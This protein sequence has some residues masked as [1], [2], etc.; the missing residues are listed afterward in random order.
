MSHNLMLGDTVP[1]RCSVWCCERMLPFIERVAPGNAAVRALEECMAVQ[2]AAEAAVQARVQST[3]PPLYQS[4]RHNFDPYDV[5]GIDT[6]TT[7]TLLEESLTVAGFRD[8]GYPGNADDMKHF[9]AL[10]GQAP[11]VENY[12]AA[13]GLI[14]VLRLYASFF[15]R[16]TSAFSR[17]QGYIRESR[18]LLEPAVMFLKVVFSLC[19]TGLSLVP[20]H[21]ASL[22]EG[23]HAYLSYGN[24]DANRYA[25]QQLKEAMRQRFVPWATSGVVPA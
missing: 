25:S 4:A 23:R 24:R 1:T 11:P 8:R 21:Q 5:P 10:E 7:M 9:W 20:G 18:P 14:A 15:R 3:Y 19:E 2:L 13:F 12:V 6:A 22:C 17:A 16:S